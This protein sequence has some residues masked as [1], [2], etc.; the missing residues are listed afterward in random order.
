MITTNLKKA[1]FK[2]AKNW[3]QQRAPI[4]GQ[5]HKFTKCGFKLVQTLKYQN[6]VQAS[7][8]RGSTIANQYYSTCIPYLLPPVTGR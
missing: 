4:T 5:N 1:F 6:P 8:Y 3:R 7:R 2:I